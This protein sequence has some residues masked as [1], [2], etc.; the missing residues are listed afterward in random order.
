METQSVDPARIRMK[1]RNLQG[2][3]ADLQDELE[4]ATLS[5][6]DIDAI[7]EG[8]SDFEKGKTRRL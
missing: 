2:Q 1:I 5:D 4:D 6:D 7:N 8:L 3:I